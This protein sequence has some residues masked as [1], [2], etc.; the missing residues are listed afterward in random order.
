M[1]MNEDRSIL[2]QIPDLCRLISA[3]N[4]NVFISKL[5]PSHVIL[6]EKQKFQDITMWM[7]RLCSINLILHIHLC[8]SSITT[9]DKFKKKVQ[10]LSI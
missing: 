6:K 5:C 4:T 8:R 10:S 9:R 1:R 2:L 3:N 7:G